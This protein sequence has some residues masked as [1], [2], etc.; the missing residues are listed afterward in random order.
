MEAL[1]EFMANIGLDLLLVG[2]F[3]VFILTVSIGTYFL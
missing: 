3:L 2:L 1:Y